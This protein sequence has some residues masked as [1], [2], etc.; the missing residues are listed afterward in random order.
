MLKV[1]EIFRSIQGEGLLT[2]H[3]MTFLRLFGCNLACKYCDTDYAKSSTT[4]P[5]N[6]SFEDLTIKEV[7]NRVKGLP[8]RKGYWVCITGGEP[9]VQEE[10]LGRLV[11]LLSL[12]G[13][14]ITIET[15]GSFP[16]PDW[17]KRVTSW[18]ADIKCPSSGE[19]GRSL[20]EWFYQTPADQV[21]FVVSDRK[22]LI[23]VESALVRNRERTSTILVSPCLEL[24]PNG[25]ISKQSKI[26][27]PTVASFCVEMNVV[28]SFQIHKVIWGAK[29]GV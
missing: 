21:K 16:K 19:G 12:E 9:L 13:I 5:G 23:F 7:I 28:F 20:D 29:R 27:V 4:I 25:E 10:E 17:A 14:K 6:R 11:G 24:M 2:G 22:D 15:N 8:T 3:P 26:W 1:N 18:N